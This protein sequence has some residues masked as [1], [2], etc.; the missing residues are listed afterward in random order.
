MLNAAAVTLALLGKIQA[1]APL[2]ALMPDGAWFAE[3]P[4]GAKRFIIV[5]L[6]SAVDVPMFGGV[7]Y[8]DLLYLIEA[9]ALSSL[10]GSVHAA[11]ARLTALLT[12]GQL[13]IPGYGA[14][15]MRF[16]EDLEFVEVDATDPSLRWNRCGGHLH[17]QVTTATV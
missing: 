17:V 15:L 6:I 14:M 12:D 9:R 7:A 1:D 13:A 3:A 2:L 8:K 10:S 5:S 11:Y 16:E 4:A